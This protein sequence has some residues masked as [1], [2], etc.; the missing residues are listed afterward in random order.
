[1]RR[2]VILSLLCLCSFAQ[3]DQTFQLPSF[4]AVKSDGVFDIDI[5]VGS[6]QSVVFKGSAEKSSKLS[7]Q[8]VDGELIITGPEEKHIINLSSDDKLIISVPSLRLYKGKGVGEVR[9]KNIDADRIDIAYEG[10]G[11]LEA[12]GK[13]KWLRLKGNGVGGINTK[14]L[15]AENAD[16]DFDGVGGVDIYVTNHLN[17][18]VNGIGSLT[19]YGNPRSINKSAGGIGSIGAGK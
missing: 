14:K 11:S 3:A 18:V 19:Y 9:I 10:V 15:I 13:T 8:V 12:S 17:A 1:M 2:L 5:S 6:T 16:V 4:N 7:L